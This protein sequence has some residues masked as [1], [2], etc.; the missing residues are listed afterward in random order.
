[1]DFNEDEKQECRRLLE[2]G[3]KEDLGEAGDI[4]SQSTIPAEAVGS[5]VIVPR[6]A[7]VV[8]GLPALQ[9]LA[10][11]RGDRLKVELF[12]MDGPA[13]EQQPVARLSGPTREILAVERLALN[14]LSHLSGIA[15]LTARY[16]AAACGTK[17]EIRD[18]R[19]TL[20]GWR[21][22]AKYAVR[23]GGGTNHRIGLYDA[24]LIKDNHLAALAKESDDPI[25]A[26]IRATR[27]S[28]PA[29]TIVEVEVDSL[30]QL[31]QALNCGPDIVLLDNMGPENLSLAVEIRD[32]KAPDVLLEAS[33]KITLD[34]I[35]AI[36]A[37]GIDI[38]SIGALT[39]SAPILDLGLD[40]E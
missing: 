18:T 36:A 16:V 4:T 34:R 35:P 13:Q 24:V 39:H 30:T 23:I 6:S 10:D 22:L 3:L 2:W 25:A 11:L 33:G 5:A 14:V 32:L 40:Y 19:K 17:A 38:I 20:P 7:G 27:A 1:M 26:A 21:H 8:A 29:G 37:T 15:T 9:I 28:V 12:S 31:E